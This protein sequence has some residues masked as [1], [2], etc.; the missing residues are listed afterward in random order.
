[1]T[2]LARIDGGGDLAQFNLDREQVDL[3]K[4]TICRDATDDELAL[5]VQVVN[6]TG[7]DPF[8]RQIYAIKRWD[9]NLRREVMGIQTSI[10]G[11]RLIAQRSREYAGQL[12]PYWC[13]PDGE[14]RDVWL[15]SDYPAAAKVGVLRRDFSEPLWA[16]ARWV[17]YVQTKKDGGVTKM[18]AQM[19]DVMLGKCAES[20]A[21]RRAFPAE[22]SGLYTADEMAQATSEPRVTPASSPPPPAMQGNADPET[23]EIVAPTTTRRPPPAAPTV[24]C[25][26]SSCTLRFASKAEAV[27]HLVTAHG[28]TED[29]G[30]VHPPSA[31]SSTDAGPP[32]TDDDVRTTS[33]GSGVPTGGGEAASQTVVPPPASG[34]SEPQMR[35]LHAAIRSGMGRAPTDPERHM[36]A[37]AILDRDVVSFNSLTKVE[38]GTL[39]ERAEA[40][41]A[42][43]PAM[44]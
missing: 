23:G 20:L 14:W 9:N 26:E 15:S 24:P 25:P 16:V 34:A 19:P 32:A 2:A 29:G 37:S 13:G 39:I 8:A 11:F 38:A 12:G 28:W 1:M 3:V 41:D 22:L 33:A 7:L 40:G 44:L 36:W 43:A 17:S 27:P 21:L 42:P 18:W 35:K 10:D 31:P 30:K 5:F 6:R 4:R